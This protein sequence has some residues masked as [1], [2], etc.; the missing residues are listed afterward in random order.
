M[1]LLVGSRYRLSLDIYQLQNVNQKGSQDF[2]FTL[3]P[4]D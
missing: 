3:N 4:I 2:R 1:Q